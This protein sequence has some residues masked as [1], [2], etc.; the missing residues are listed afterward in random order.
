MPKRP[1]LPV[2]TSLRFFAAMAVVCF[3][4]TITLP[5]GALDSPN[6]V[7]GVTLFG[8][9]AVTFFFILSGFILTYAH[10]AGRE[11]DASKIEPV[12]FWRSRFARIFPAY[13]LG[14]LLA[15]PFLVDFIERAEPWEAVA[16]PLLVL[17]FLQTW[18]PPFATIWNYPA[19]SLSVEALFYALF[20]WL[21]RA[22]ER[23]PRGVAF[24]IV[25]ALV[26]VSYESRIAALGAA[27]PV[28]RTLF[29]L[30]VFHLPMFMFGM[31]LGRQFLFGRQV[32]PAAHGA[33]FATGVAALALLFSF[34]ALM[35]SWMK[36]EGVLVLIFSLVIFGGA[37]TGGLLA[38]PLFVL[39]GEAS[40]AIYILHVPV[41]FWWKTMAFALPLPLDIFLYCCLVV[42][43]SILAFRCVETPMRKAIG[44]QA[45]VS[46]A[47]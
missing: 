32:G 33:L 8:H 35:P 14:L 13:F 27:D 41:R 9:A 34:N 5:G 44:R 17:L 2:L 19:W 3:H 37:R 45:R 29:A 23:C 38:S 6:V 36:G 40:Y 20:P 42:V 46:I 22:I 25:Y 11:S 10:A 31:V 12:A 24:A 26:V 15:L 1:A 47:G 28:T 18:W 39:L 7:G 21:A 16:G 43:V 4:V 30:P